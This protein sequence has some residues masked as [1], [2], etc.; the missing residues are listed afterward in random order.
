M[1]ITPRFIQQVFAE[2]P[3]V[4]AAFLE[5]VP[6]KMDEKEFWTRFAKHEIQVQVRTACLFG[7]DLLPKPC[8]GWIDD[9]FGCCIRLCR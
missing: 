4:R 1:T 3:H 2:K 8:N 9:S 7:F 5:N 6:Q